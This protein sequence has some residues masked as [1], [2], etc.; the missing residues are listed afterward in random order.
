MSA[1]ARRSVVGAS[2][3][4]LDTAHETNAAAPRTG[5][6]YTWLPDRKCH[7]ARPLPLWADTGV[8]VSCRDQCGSD[9]AHVA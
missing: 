3:Q 8:S 9:T 4:A 5:S 7:G 6:G 1:S 2:D